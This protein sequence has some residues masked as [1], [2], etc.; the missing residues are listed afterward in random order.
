VKYINKERLE[1]GTCSLA[2]NFNKTLQLIEEVQILLVMK[3][4]KVRGGFGHKLIMGLKKL[5]KNLF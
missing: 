1:E 2:I 5:E 3:M 4:A